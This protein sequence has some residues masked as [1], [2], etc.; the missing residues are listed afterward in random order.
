MIASKA[1][2]KNEKKN[3]NSINFNNINNNNHDYDD[4]ENKEISFEG[5]KTYIM[6]SAC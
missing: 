5:H 1:G 2:K 3:S 6:P 4:D